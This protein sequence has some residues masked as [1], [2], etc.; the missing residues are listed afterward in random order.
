MDTPMSPSAKAGSG[1]PLKQLEDF[2]DLYLVK[3]APFQLPKGIK[4]FIVNFGPW[5]TLILIIIGLPVLLLALG[6]TAVFLPFAAAS[7]VAGGGVTS[8]LSLILTIVAVACE[9][10]ALPGLFKRSR[11]GWEFMFYAT[12]ASGVGNLLTANI[13]AVISVVISLYFVFQVKEYY[14]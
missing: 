2:L 3:K 4:E 8:T 9:V 11:H 6:L 7:A 5:I 1:N 14:K 13:G 12:L 10:I